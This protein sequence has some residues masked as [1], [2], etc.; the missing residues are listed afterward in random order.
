MSHGMHRVNFSES[1]RTSLD[2]PAGAIEA[3]VDVPK[4]PPTGIA[5]VAH[6]QPLLGGHAQHKVPA[7]LARALADR[8]FA[9]ARPNFRGVEGS[10]GTHDHGFGEADD[11]QVVAE[12]LR[13]AHPGLPL[14]LAG[15]SFGAYVQAR[16]AARLTE[17][18]TPAW[19]V[20]LAGMPYGQV[21]SGRAFETPGGFTDAMVVHGERDEAV[22]L[23]A[24]FAWGEMAAQ[25]ITVVAG[26]DHFFAGRLPLLR[27]LLLRHVR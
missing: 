12:A 23:T 8:G 2:G 6:P 25:P 24:I 21:T 10:A 17:M 22:P 20:F 9:V 27:R 3:L 7:F 13:A 26:T 14:V 16:L 19:R 1:G 15:F 18:G 11:L 5:I 4:T